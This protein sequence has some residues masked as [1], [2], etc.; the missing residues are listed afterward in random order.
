MMIYKG[1]FGSVHYNDQDQVFY[2]KIEFIRA[3]ASYEGTDVKSLK[4]AFESA[5]DDYL[6]FCQQTNR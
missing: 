4:R 3:L 2:G 1:Y 6:I 5:V